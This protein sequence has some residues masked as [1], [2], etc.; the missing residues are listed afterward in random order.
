M[1]CSSAKLQLKTSFSFKVKPWKVQCQ[2]WDPKIAWCEVPSDCPYLTI[3]PTKENTLGWYMILML[4]LIIG[5]LFTH[6]NILVKNISQ[7]HTTL[8]IHSHSN[9][10]NT[11]KNYFNSLMW[12]IICKIVWNIDKV[13][14][15]NC[16][17]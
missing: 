1:A 7:E 8:S 10:N 13:A 2:M 15:S 5:E 9:H 6:G 17:Y 4:T 14:W 16:T 3:F 11:N 12:Y